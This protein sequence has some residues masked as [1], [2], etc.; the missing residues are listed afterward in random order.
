MWNKAGFIKKQCR[1]IGYVHR[2]LRFT[3]KLSSGFVSMIMGRLSSPFMIS[4]LFLVAN[5]YYFCE[6][7]KSYIW[8][9]FKLETKRILQNSKLVFI[10][11]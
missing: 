11:E 8:F 10:I 7:L 2:G 5:I 3:L 1:Q 6:F 4:D 9:C